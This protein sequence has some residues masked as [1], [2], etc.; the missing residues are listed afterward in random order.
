MWIEKLIN[1]RKYTFAETSKNRH[2][3]RWAIKRSGKII[4][5]GYRFDFGETL[6]LSLN[7]NSKEEDLIGLK[8]F[9]LKYPLLD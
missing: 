8:A 3:R 7:E 5:M 6:F 9:K 4:H 2:G 1:G